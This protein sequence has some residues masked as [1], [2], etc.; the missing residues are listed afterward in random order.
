MYIKKKS[1]YVE[2]QKFSKEKVTKIAETEENKNILEY[3][4]NKTRN[5]IENSTN[6]KLT[7]SWFWKNE[8]L[9]NLT[10]KNIIIQREKPDFAKKWRV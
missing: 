7:K 6:S 9:K 1:D 5:K 3:E 4:N 8:D 10:E 2:K